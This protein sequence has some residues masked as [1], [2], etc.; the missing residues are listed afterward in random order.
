MNSFL[1]PIG[2]SAQTATKCEVVALQTVSN[3]GLH[4][5][6]MPQTLSILK[7]CHVLSNT[8]NNIV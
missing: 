4:D 1:V 8:N 7:Y 2:P 5:N 3:K 6:V